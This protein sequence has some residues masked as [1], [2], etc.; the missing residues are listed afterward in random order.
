MLTYEA[1]HAY[2][3]IITLGLHEIT[4]TVN[5]QPWDNERGLNNSTEWPNIIIV[6]QPNPNTNPNQ[7]P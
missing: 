5:E 1:G 3:I 6:E 4:F 2:N 7:N